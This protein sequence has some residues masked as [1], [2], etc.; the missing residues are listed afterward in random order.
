V[1]WRSSSDIWGSNPQLEDRARQIKRVETRL[2][3]RV[4]L[5]FLDKDKEEGN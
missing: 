5:S 3:N 4:Q 2:E 1:S